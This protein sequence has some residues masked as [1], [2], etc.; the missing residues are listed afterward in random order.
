MNKRDLIESYF[1]ELFISP[2]CELNFSN[3]FELIVAVILSAQ[4]TDKRVNIVT[5]K[6]FELCPTP[7]HIIDL[8]IDK[9]KEIIKPCGFFNNKAKNIYSMCEQLFEKHNGQVPNTLNELVSLSGVG[10]K[11]ANVVLS[12]A[13]NEDAFAVDTHVKRVSQR[14]DLTNNQN[15]LKIEQDLNSYFEKAKWSKLHYQMVLFGR[16][17]CKARNPDCNNCKLKDICKY[18]KRK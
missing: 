1:D 9:L 11:T 15:P 18:Y 6:L 5:K 2:K 7:K 3:N 17:V 16:Y 8:G 12:V 14:L 10:K 4:C 13:F